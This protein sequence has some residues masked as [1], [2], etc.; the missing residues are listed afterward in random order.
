MAVPGTELV[1]AVS[2]I[3][4]AAT[5]NMTVFPL[6]VMAARLPAVKRRHR[7]GNA[8]RAIERQD[9]QGDVPITID[10]PSAS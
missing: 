5:A 7:K 1:Q 4:Q 9:A 10:A 8:N 2:E 6:I 3:A